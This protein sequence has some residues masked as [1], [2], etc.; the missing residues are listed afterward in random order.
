MGFEWNDIKNAEN[1]IKH[2]LSFQ[3]A[4]EAFFD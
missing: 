2:G 4:Q 3:E 1:I